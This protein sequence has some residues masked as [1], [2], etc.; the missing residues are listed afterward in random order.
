VLGGPL[1]LGALAL[2]AVQVG[3]W[4]PHY[5]TWPWWPDLDAYALLAQSWESGILP[6]R[7]ITC[8]NF[9]GQI[10]L[11]G[12]IGR[13][14][15][16]G[17]TWAI[18][19]L[20]A[21]LLCGL[22]VLLLVWSRKRFGNALPGLIA[23]LGVANYY[24][25]QDYALAAQRDW[26]GPV[27]AAGSI[28]VLQMS[29][30]V[31]ASAVAGFLAAIGF[32]IRPHV[33]LFAP[34]AL[35]AMLWPGSGTPPARGRVFLG[36]SLG[37]ILGLLITFAP[38]ARVVPSFLKGVRQAA[39]GSAY[40][41]RTPETFLR[42]LGNQFLK[43][44][45]GSVAPSVAVTRRLAD[46][47]MAFAIGLGLALLALHVL[48]I[49]GSKPAIDSM[50]LLAF[51]TSLVY[52]PLHPK[53]HAYLAHPRH[54][55]AAITLGSVAG[56]L[57][58]HGGASNPRRT[59]VLLLGLLIVASPGMPRFF[60]PLRSIEGIR[61]LARGRPP[62][63]APL[64]AV[65]HFRPEDPRALIRWND[66]RDS[67]VYLSKATT[68]ETLVAN[69][70]R[71]KPLL[72]IN[73]PIARLS[74]WPAE[75]GIVWIYSVDPERERDFLTAL[76]SAPAGTAVVWDPDLPASLPGMEVELLRQGVRRWFRREAVFGPI[77][78]W[79]KF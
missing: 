58:A 71:N 26:Q 32:A 62:D 54:L 72:A 27:L 63:V 56:S 77:E 2:L 10:E 17:R 15:G 59:S 13:L 34:A 68:A 1:A 28:L 44:Y 67:L 61:I 35:V 48:P 64:G 49:Q 6:Y 19:A 69:L 4:L 55:L 75:S 51:A 24:L 42:G 20:D 74:P 33:V 76:E 79:R 16:R 31:A 46:L 11:F 39:Y 40:S 30:G 45:P 53:W 38:L 12:V 47:R 37:V 43:E 52:E 41:E 60:D 8:F 78:V 65:E 29:R 36:V 3:G 18:Y 73:G 9:P 50:W 57:L 66:Y 70:V 7:D 25:G 21:A 5:L 23:A 14:G 22:L